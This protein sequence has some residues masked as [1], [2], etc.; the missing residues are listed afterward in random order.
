MPIDS[1]WTVIRKELPEPVDF[2]ELRRLEPKTLY[3]LVMR[4]HN[5]LGWSNYSS[6]DFVFL[7]TEGIKLF[8][9]NLF[10]Q[11]RFRI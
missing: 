2:V 1:E 4:V 9:Y 3:Q 11:K 8:L 10:M 5:Q 7:T 6:S